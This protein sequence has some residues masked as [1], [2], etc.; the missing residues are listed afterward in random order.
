MSDPRFEH[1]LQ[2]LF[3]Q[4]PRRP[5]ADLFA[6]QVRA[7]LDRDWTVRRML[8]G[9]AGAGAGVAALWQLAGAQL[10][11]R[12]EELSTTPIASLWP[13][14]LP[15][16]G[17]APALRALP[18]PMEVVWLCGGLMLLAAGML[19]TRVVDEF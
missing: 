6:A 9:V 19:V 4:A 16:G 5:D 10:M 17:A 15:L 8:I 1:D 3:A 12:L 2:R 11:R 18:V 7:R 14:G 13:E